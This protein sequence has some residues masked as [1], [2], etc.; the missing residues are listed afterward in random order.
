MGRVSPGRGA[1]LRRLQVGRSE[2]AG[3]LSRPPPPPQSDQEDYEANRQDYEVSGPSPEVLGRQ[4]H[5]GPNC[6][7]DA[8]ADHQALGWS[9]LH[10]SE[11]IRRRGQT[12]S[13]GTYRS[14]GHRLWIARRG[15]VGHPIVAH[16][17]IT[18]AGPSNRQGAVGRRR[19]WRKLYWPTRRR[20]IPRCIHAHAPPWPGQPAPTFRTYAGGPEPIARA[21]Q[22]AGARRIAPL[23]HPQGGA[24]PRGSMLMRTPGGPDR[25]RSVCT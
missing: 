21:G 13:S 8:G 24:Y 6:S 18:R 1:I 4:G 20:S 25:D 2:S 15:T 22:Q 5:H 16:C 11:S 10:D 7:Q 23:A 12:T 19:P 17:P 9:P 3:G 14:V